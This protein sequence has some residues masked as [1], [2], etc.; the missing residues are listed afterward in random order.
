[1][2]KRLTALEAAVIRRMLADPELSPL[3]RTP[4]ALDD[5]TV[6]DRSFSGVGFMTDVAR[7][8]AARLFRADTSL[9]WGKV[10]GRLDGALDVDFVIYVDDGFVTAIEGVTFGG[11][12]WPAAI[13]EFELSDIHR[14]K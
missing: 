14:E 6:E 5:I 9:R 11:D 10:L 1:M 13:N 2:S 4:D 3:E 8:E 7:S 12:E